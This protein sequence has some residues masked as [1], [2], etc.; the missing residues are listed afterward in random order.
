M[1][2]II[3]RLF[4]AFAFIYVMRCAILYH[5][6]NLKNMKN[7]HGGVLKKEKNSNLWALNLEKKAVFQRSQNNII[8]RKHRFATQKILDLA[9]VLFKWL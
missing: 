2:H 9:L 5:L 4:N 1:I 8:P 7:T 3:A 6:Y